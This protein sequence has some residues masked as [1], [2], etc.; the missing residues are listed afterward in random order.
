MDKN[1]SETLF[2]EP[3]LTK[4]TYV[5]NTDFDNPIP[6]CCNENAEGFFV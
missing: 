5:G 4:V 2:A 1:I 3:S 6:E